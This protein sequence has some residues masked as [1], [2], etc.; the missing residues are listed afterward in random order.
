MTT[1]RPDSQWLTTG[2]AARLCAVERD[3]VLKWIKRGRIP[4]ARTAGGHYRIAREDLGRLLKLPCAGP[5]LRT[6][7]C[8]EYLAAGAE[9][10]SE[11]GTCLAFEA[12]AIRCFRLRQRNQDAGFFC[13]GPRN[14]EDCPYYRKVAGLPARVLVITLDSTFRRALEPADASVEMTFASSSYEASRRVAELWPALVVVDEEVDRRE[15]AKLLE[16]LLS[17]R[18][19]A[20]SR[21]LYAVAGAGRRVRLERLRSKQVLGVMKKPF[22]ISTIRRILAEEPVEAAPANNGVQ[23][24]GE[25][26]E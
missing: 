6:L 4:A 1:D 22:G 8:W 13:C 5:Q 9:I 12:E 11:C 20:G 17:D 2:E 23:N 7:R 3:T 10:R 21:I 18:A 24:G 25:R 15:G 19:M 16:S 14:C 26:K